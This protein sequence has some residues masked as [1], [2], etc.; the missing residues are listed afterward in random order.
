MM[1]HSGHACGSSPGPSPKARA[2]VAAVLLLA[3][4]AAFA[5]ADGATGAGL[6]EALAA[7]QALVR[8]R[9]NQLEDRLFRLARR[10]SDV[11]PDQRRRLEDALRRSRE[12]LIRRAMD[13]AVQALQQAD[14]S[15]AADRQEEAARALE[16][17]L[18]LL[19]REPDPAARLQAEQRGLSERLQ[20]VQ[21]LLARQRELTDRTRQEASASPTTSAPSDRPGLA[22][23]QRQL[24][25]STEALAARE[26]PDSPSSD[27]GSPDAAPAGAELKQAAG[28]MA[29]A[30]GKLDHAAPA[31][32]TDPQRRA[33]EALEQAAARLQRMLE[34][35]QQELREL[36]RKAVEQRL[37]AMADRQAEINAATAGLDRS[38]A[39]ADH[40]PD[41]RALAELADNQDQLAAEAGALLDMLADREDVVA[42]PL[43][44]ET[45]RT[46]MAASAIRLKRAELGEGTLNL[47]QR[48]LENLRS[49]L[50]S[51]EPSSPAAGRNPSDGQPGD[52]SRGGSP[53]LLPAEAELKL[54]RAAQVQ[55]MTLTAGLDAAADLSAEARGDALRE[56]SRRQVRL[57]EAARRMAR[58]LEGP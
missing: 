27:P 14:L 28:H 12:L 6:A 41:G 21:A 58:S 36:L 48:I 18:E 2:A 9:L 53:G 46:D 1:Y 47:Q 32:A 5:R 11:D 51:L 19:L 30:A 4:V 42:L 50:E 33:A 16:L 23:A 29:D 17:V 43:V 37:R 45:V 10:E 26:S 56:V 20:Q 49:C 25:R 22:E 52:D 44:L 55:L 57:A 34:A 31:E 39:A 13:Q 24:Q 38:M 35:A 54:L 15:A 7:R 40:R 8:E 3:G